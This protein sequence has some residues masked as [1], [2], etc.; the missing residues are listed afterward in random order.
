[1]IQKVNKYISHIVHFMP[2][3]VALAGLAVQ[4]QP[5]ARLSLW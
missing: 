4:L 1:M 3:S 2:E 5:S